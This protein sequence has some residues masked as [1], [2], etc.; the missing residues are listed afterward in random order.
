M[1]SKDQIAQIVELSTSLPGSYCQDI[2]IP[3]ADREVRMVDLLPS[4]RVEISRDGKAAILV[5]RS[6]VTWFLCAL[7]DVAT[8]GK[9]VLDKALPAGTVFYGSVRNEQLRAAILKARPDFIATGN[10]ISDGGPS[11]RLA[12]GVDNTKPKRGAR[13]DR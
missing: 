2:E 9:E 12:L 11:S 3:I 8:A 6:H 5:V 4:G 1:L 7:A 10:T 13:R